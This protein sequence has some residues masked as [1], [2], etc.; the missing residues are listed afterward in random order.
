[1]LAADRSSPLPE[2]ITQLA[3]VLIEQ[4]MAADP[5]D[6][7]IGQR[8]GAWRIVDVIGSSGMG[9]VYRVH[10]DDG[11]Y[12]S[13]AALKIVASRL[14]AARFLHERAVLARLQHPHIAGLLDGGEDEDGRPYLVM[15][16]VAGRRIDLWCSYRASPATEVL[17]QGI[18]AARAVAYAHAR[19]VLHRDLKPANILI[20]DHGQ[21][22]LLDFGVAKL[23]DTTDSDPAL[24]SARFFTPR[25]AAPEQF[26]GEVA[27][28]ATDIYALA[29][30]IYELLSG[31]HP[32]D[33]DGEG[34][35]GT[36]QQRIM[37]C[38]A[39]PLHR[40][41]AIS[42]RQV[43][44]AAHRLRDLE[45]VLARALQTD[46]Q[47]RYPGMEAFAD[48]L[49]RVLDDRPV[50]TRVPGAFERPWRWARRHRLAA[51]MALLALA[52]LLTGSSVALWQAMEARQQRDAALLE[53][54]RAERLGT[55]LADIFRAPNPA[56][57][58]GVE[59]SARELLDRGR[60]RIASELGDDPVLRAR[61]QSVM[62]DTYR[63]LGLY[64]EAEDMLLEA[65]SSKDE[66]MHRATLL[67]DLGWVHAFQGRH[68][69]SAAR[70]RESIELLRQERG[71]DAL[72][73]LVIALQR[74]ATPLINLGQIEA[75]EAAAS[76][77]LALDATLPSPDLSRQAS[78]QGLLG[79]VAYN[80]G[81]L[82]GARARYEMALDT[83]KRL[84]GE[85][86]TAVAVGLGNL[87]TIAFRQGDLTGAISLYREAIALQRAFFGVDNVQVA[88]PM[89]NMGLAL[90][91][92]GRGAEAL[93]ALR[94]AAAIH[95]AWSGENHPMTLQVRLDTLELAL[96]LGVDAETELA[97]LAS[98]GANKSSSELLNCRRELLLAQ[99][100]EENDPGTLRVGQSC[101]ERLEAP[102]AVRAH[103][104]LGLARAA[105]TPDRLEAARVQ[106]Q[107]LQPR[108]ALL[109]AA[110]DALESL[111]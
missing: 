90:R 69:D 31:R 97:A 74:L 94:E 37:R 34:A 77:A 45:A 101:L 53:A 26:A 56:R 38:E 100:A 30:V 81:D 76:E 16:Y 29:V 46:P 96:L 35:R 11:R 63:S 83:Q 60:E 32:H 23:L 104:A 12:D 103:A 106:V 66:R 42:G 58:R 61:L 107:A 64:D 4:A 102:A 27:T 85:G 71:S 19:A 54:A 14:D 73:A 40:A 111:P 75:A 15:E 6:A 108:D 95:A 93:A 68:E 70:L 25:Y 10:R 28:T 72:D 110:L 47:A 36:L 67:S 41:I 91:R 92:L 80:R 98:A 105:P 65:L 57:S 21:L 22:K 8:L 59:V 55:F 20:D 44:L 62:A 87:A 24:T 18:S 50:H 51:S 99:A 109:D 43:L 52:S 9:H 39:L 82:A 49:Q 48:E 86:H 88:A 1:M 7:M 78:L 5:P 89:A 13:V 79:S 84:H 3:P 2:S 33:P 17:A